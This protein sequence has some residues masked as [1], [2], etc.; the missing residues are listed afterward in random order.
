MEITFGDRKLQKLCEQQDLA[1]RKLGANCAKKLR[2][3][4]AD[5]AAVS[6]VTELVMGRPHPLTGDRAGEFAVDLEGGTRLVF[7]PDNEPIPLNEDG[8]IDW[9]KVTAVC[10]V[11]IGD[12]HD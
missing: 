1:Q 10:I 4:L 12:Y 5:L 2:T 9:S 8:S 6:C 11:F 7:K 3:R